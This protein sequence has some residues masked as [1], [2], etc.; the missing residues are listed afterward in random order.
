[1]NKRLP[2]KPKKTMISKFLNKIILAILL[3]SVGLIAQP[4]KTKVDGV[5]AVVGEF[6]V[7][8]SDI[9]VMLI[10]LK[11]QGVDTEKVTRCELLG[12]QLEDKIYA[13]Q[14]IQDS[15]KV[16]D[17]EI[18]SVMN[19][20]I[21]R[22][23][24]RLGSKDK[25]YEFYKKK[26]EDDFKSYFSEIIKMNKLTSQMQQK[27]IDDITVTPDEVKSFFSTLK[28]EDIPL[29]S[30]EVEIAQIV[31]KPIVTPEVKKETI[32]KL[33][34]IKKDI[35][36]GNSSFEMKVKIYSEDPGSSE[37][38]GYY[39]I[40]RKTQFV[41]E[42]KEVA[43]RL[44]EGEI[45]EPFETEFGYHIIQCDKIIGQQ[46]E[47]RHIVISPKVSDDAVKEAYEKLEKLKGKIDAKEISFEDA[48]RSESDDKDTR[49]NGGV[50]VNPQSGEARFEV[51]KIDPRL[52]SNIK[53]LNE[54][55]VSKVVLDIDKTTK[56]FKIIK[57]NKKVSSHKADFSTDY[58]KIKEMAL[59]DKQFKK[60][61][62]WMDE[63]I[64]KTYI[65]INADYKNCD[66]ANNWLKISK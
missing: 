41:K 46:R 17:E 49:V 43:F 13:H 18:N 39:K 35:V 19:Q 62:K 61:A 45:S 37:N 60:I 36:E 50:L 27:V 12:K 26:N 11:Q 58:L 6:V 10:E 44:D 38:G 24:E 29:I 16:T 32:D 15:I 20:E 40:D 22:L 28:P 21:S 23:V 4:K 65:N 5:A 3:F 33:N 59:T 42:F 51:T 2:M 57:I 25:V 54:G 66:F 8:D 63:T 55:E 30:E 34:E 64:E 1:M 14:A 53:A 56:V 47:I 9:D 48:A 52:Y 31:A 7:L